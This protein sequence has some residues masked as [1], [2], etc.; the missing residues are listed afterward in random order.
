MNK[1]L[2]AFLLAMIV[3]AMLIGIVVSSKIVA[4]QSGQPQP[5]DLTVPIPQQ[6]WE[7]RILDG[8][9]PT[10]QNQ[11]NQL[12]EQGFDI[13]AAN[14]TENDYGYTYFHMVLKRPKP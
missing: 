13:V 11:A 8:E 14:A 5:G 2:C 10:V 9:P 12:G 3:L 1:K 4:A 7:F 6:K